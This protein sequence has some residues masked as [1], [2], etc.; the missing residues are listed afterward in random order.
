M[1]DQP[2]RA[3]ARFCPGCGEPVVARANYCAACGAALPGGGRGGAAR[4]ASPQRL[5]AP[6]SGLAVLVAFLA[7]GLSLWF[8]ILRP[9]T[10]TRK[11][12]APK[13]S[14]TA[15]GA[16]EPG[17][18]G[19]AGGAT[20][21]LPANHPP[22]SL[23]AEVGSFI[24]ELEQKATAQ[25]KD[26]GTWLQLA[27]VQYRA[28]Q[29]EASYLGAAEKSFRHVLE[30]EPK[31]ADAL[32][33]VGNIHFDR[34]QYAPAIEAY[35]AYL[36][37]RPDDSST[38]TDLGTMYLYDG[39]VEDAV[40][41]YEGVLARE[42]G[43]FQAHFNLGIAQVRRGNRAAALAAFE[44]AKERAPDEDTRKQI[45]AMIARTSGEA[46]PPSGPAAGGATLESR[47]EQRLRSHPVAGPKVVRVE[48]PKP[49]EA[50]AVLESFPMDKMPEFARQKF[51]DR[52]K[53]DLVEARREAGAS[54]AIRLE[55]VDQGSGTVMATVVAGE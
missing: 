11:P 53:T 16:G 20:G 44:K 3:S 35:R 52:I 37:V 17:T 15:G 21:S 18:A 29:I 42:P 13:A 14:T 28:G 39:R 45:E 32:R 40:R 33:G 22:V 10:V 50:R 2:S 34:D 19:E 47:V 31:N 36:E 9:E 38:R 25:P 24:V 6:K 7:I 41:E 43:F 48:W 4:A 54:G 12:L 1:S 30:V 51:L 49:G 27:Q 23:P 55:I 46:A 8:F 5:R 26:V